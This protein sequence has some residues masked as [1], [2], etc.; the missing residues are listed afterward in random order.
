[1]SRQN[2]KA[3]DRSVSKTEKEKEE[4]K[5]QVAKEKLVEQEKSETGRVGIMIVC[6]LPAFVHTLSLSHCTASL[7]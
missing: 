7:A 4:K 6:F 3:L 5:P 1:M 2:S